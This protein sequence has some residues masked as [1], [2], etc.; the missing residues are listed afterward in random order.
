MTL[1]LLVVFV[2]MAVIVIRQLPA[3]T[4]DAVWAWFR[5]ITGV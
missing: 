2:G 5:S 3:A 4:F 1:V